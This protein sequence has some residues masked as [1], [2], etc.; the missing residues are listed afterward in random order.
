[1]TARPQTAIGAALGSAG[2]NTI[3]ARLR[4]VILDALKK[5]HRDIPRALETFERAIEGD[6]E[7]IR[8]TKLWAVLRVDDEMLGAGHTYRDHHNAHA[9]AQ[10]PNRDGADLSAIA[11]NGHLGAVRPVCEPSSLQR[12][13][14]ATV[15]KFV[16]R[17]VFDTNKTNDGRAWGDVG[18]HELDH[19]DRDGALAR[20]IKNRLG[21]LHGKQRFK[22]LRELMT[23]ATFEDAKRT[24]LETTNVA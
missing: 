16:A 4:Q 2:F 21:V 17:T 24:A 19:M 15:A 1:M 22:P 20:A 12:K 23:P 14:A 5:H 3:E 11:R 18:A 7:L 9:G 13:A 6:A 10:Q 8:E